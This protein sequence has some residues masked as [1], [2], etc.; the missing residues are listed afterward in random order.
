MAYNTRYGAVTWRARRVV[1]H[2]PLC[3][4]V[5]RV[6]FFSDVLRP[7]VVVEDR[8][9]ARLRLV[10]E[11]YERPLLHR[12]APK[13][14]LRHRGLFSFCAFEE[15]AERAFCQRGG[16]DDDRRWRNLRVR[17]SK[18]G[19]DTFPP[20]DQA[21]QPEIFEGVWIRSDRLRRRCSAVCSSA[22][23]VGNGADVVGGA[24][25]GGG[26]DPPC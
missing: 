26:P 9:R 12:P 25:K 13:F 5:L 24:L 6:T 23:D 11:F 22:D 1:R 7:P 14:V 8:I 4:Q 21:V 10:D 3:V 17:A 20:G 19:G 16:E 2:V 15:A 18:F